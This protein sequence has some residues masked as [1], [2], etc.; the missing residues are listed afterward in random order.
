MH[1]ATEMGTAT[2]TGQFT[3]TGASATGE[4]HI[5]FGAGSQTI[6]MDTQWQGTRIG[7]C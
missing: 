1:C 2:G 4:M 7:D 3:S 6:A 5:E